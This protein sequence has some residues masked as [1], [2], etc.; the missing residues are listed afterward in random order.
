[1]PSR[2]RKS[3]TSLRILLYVSHLSVQSSPNLCSPRQPSLG[4]LV[5]FRMPS[6]PL[7]EVTVS[8][9]PHQTPVVQPAP[10][11]LVKF[12]GSSRIVLKQEEEVVTQVV[13]SLA[14]V[15]VVA[16]TPTPTTPRT[17]SAIPILLRVHDPMVLGMISLPS[18]G[19]TPAADR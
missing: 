8:E 19:L 13:A 1:M 5:I 7:V 10:S 17:L 6:P 4:T 14:S 12:S 18:S 16:T 2:S 9:V 3:S 15:V 11:T